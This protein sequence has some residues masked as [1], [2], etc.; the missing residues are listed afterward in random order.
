MT[1]VPECLTHNKLIRVIHCKYGNGA[2][3]MDVLPT[4]AVDSQRK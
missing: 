1:L 4:I 2:R 3:P